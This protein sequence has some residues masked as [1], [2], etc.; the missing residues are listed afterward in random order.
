VHVMGWIMHRSALVLL[1]AVLFAAAA[2]VEARVYKWVDKKG[3]THYGE[4]VPPEYANANITELDDKGRVVSQHEV[5]TP[6]Q[7]AARAEA[8]AK[9]RAEEQAALDQKRHDKALVS[10]YNSEQEIDLARDRSLKQVNAMLD[11]LRARLKIEQQG[12]NAT[13]AAQVQ[14]EIG[15]R[16]KEA[17]DIRARF[18][19][20]KQRY[21]ELTTAAPKQ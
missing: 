12:G 4:T 17:A 21:R 3:I 10:S 9:K 15:Q 7:A 16:E 6:E 20:D 13:R 14:Q 19:A 1:G 11:S 18:E 5:L 2:N 8:E